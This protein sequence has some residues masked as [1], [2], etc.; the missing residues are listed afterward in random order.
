M[1]RFS[2][3]FFAACAALL[4]I[5]ALGGIAYAYEVSPMR[6]T[7]VPADGRDNTTLSVSNTRDRDLPVEVRVLRRMIAEDGSQTFEPA[8]DDFL[9]FPPQF[10]VEPDASQ[11]LRVQYIGIPPQDEAL[12]Y[13]VQ[14]EEVPV[15]P[16]G[17]S[18]V[19]FTYNFGV[20]VYVEPANAEDDLVATGH[21]RDGSVTL[22]ITNRGNAFSLLS[23]KEMTL[24]GNSY[25]RRFSPTDIA[26]VIA[27][28]LIAPN[29][30]RTFVVEDTEAPDG[31]LEAVEFRS[32]GD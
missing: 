13:V 18:G 1:Q 16:E 32:F 28:P 5:F 24:R 30:T 2:K 3:R 11:A 15:V 21:A 10:E 27:M 20:A 31:P 26:E 9:V 14:V 12:A 25:S 22:E 23:L 29:T 8:D 4:A 17:F 19:K 7:L 6:V